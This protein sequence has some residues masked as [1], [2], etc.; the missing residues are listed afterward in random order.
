[1]CFFMEYLTFT[2]EESSMFTCNTLPT[3]DVRIWEQNGIILY[4]FY[5]KPTVGNRVIH[6]NSALPNMSKEATSPRSCP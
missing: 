6:K 3:L 2:M 1:M 5:E 4:S